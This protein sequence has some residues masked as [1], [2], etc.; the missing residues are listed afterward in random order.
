[1]AIFDSGIFDSGIFGVEGSVVEPPIVVTPPDNYAYSP[2]KAS[3]ARMYAAL[4]PAKAK[5]KAKLEKVATELIN[6][7]DPG[8]D[9]PPLDVSAMVKAIRLLDAPVKLKPTQAHKS[10]IIVA[11]LEKAAELKRQADEDEEETMI[12]AYLMAA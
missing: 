10:A 2:S 1:M 12:L 9:L 3:V 4:F 11:L 7:F 6:Q 8:P 5:R